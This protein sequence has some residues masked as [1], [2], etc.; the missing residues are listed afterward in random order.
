MTSMRLIVTH[1]FQLYSKK[2]V[3]QSDILKSLN[4]IVILHDLAR[5]KLI[6]REQ[7]RLQDQ[8]ID[9]MIV[10]SKFQLSSTVIVS[11]H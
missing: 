3:K 5:Q 8:A 10:A 11:F 7:K 1:M 9:S 4:S 6:M 2:R